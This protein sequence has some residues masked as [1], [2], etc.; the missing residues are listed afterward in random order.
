MARFGM[1]WFCKVPSNPKQF[2]TLWWLP[3]HFLFL[4]CFLPKEQLLLLLKEYVRR[5]K[6]KLSWKLLKKWQQ[7]FRAKKLNIQ[8]RWE[9]L[10]FYHSYLSALP[11]SLRTHL[12]K[13]SLWELP[14]ALG[15]DKAV[16]V[17]ELP[18]A[19]HNPLCRI[20]PC[21]AALTHRIC[22]SIRHITGTKTGVR[23][24]INTTFQLL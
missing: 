17:V 1:W 2:V 21:L 6:G 5:K 16:L 7:M 14:K 11:T 15:T 20:E 10:A 18:I 4:K 9:F 19:V 12:I 22:Q 23:M 13:E 3:K 24:F 8:E